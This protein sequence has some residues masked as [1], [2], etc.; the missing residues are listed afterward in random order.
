VF[1][2]HSSSTVAVTFSGVLIDH[3]AATGTD[4][5]SGSG[6]VGGQVQ[7]GGIAANGGALT[8][9]KTT[10][11]DNTAA[12]GTGAANTGGDGISGGQAYGGGVEA[13]G[14]SLTVTNSTIT[15]NTLSG[16]VGGTGGSSHE[17][18][19]GGSANGAGIY[20]E[21][22]GA[23]GISSS[24]L[25]GNRGTG[26]A[27]GPAGSGGHGGEGGCA[28]GGG[29]YLEAGGGSRTIA[30]DTISDN[31]VTGGAAGASATTGEPTYGSG[32][33]VYFDTAGVIE[34]TT[35]SGNHA[36]GGAPTAA[37]AGGAISPNGSIPGLVAVVNS[38]VFG[39]TASGPGSA[40]GGQGG[41]LETGSPL[42]LASDTFDANGF[43]GSHGG[44]I[45]S[46][47]A[48]LV[49][50]EDTIIAGGVGSS[51]A[52]NCSA[53]T[54]TD[55]PP[56]HNLEDD[57]GAQCGFSAGGDKV[58]VDPLLPAALASN[59][60][61]TQ[62]LALAPNS[63]ARG[64][65]GACLNPITAGPLLLDQ[66]GDA[67]GASPA[68]VLS[69]VRESH[70]RWRESGR[71]AHESRART[72]TGTKFSFRLSEAASVTF[73]FSHK[74]RK[75][76]VLT[77]HARAGRDALAFYGLLR[78]HH[79]LKPGKYKVVIVATSAGKRSRRSSLTFTIVG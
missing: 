36:I 28:C 79:E 1:I 57:A 49:H 42:T 38:T 56:G 74:G 77:V 62:T 50:A 76:G 11:A 32:G 52:Q 19:P 58:G 7:G 8:L 25:T 3:N 47:A 12:A 30:G 59:G 33:G 72:P 48:G 17:G 31:T 27:G 68:P 18:G 71:A 66:R 51:T 46:F 6:D 63:P 20:V 16:G 78:R 35:L 40:S 41:G 9:D 10:I 22:S 15:G 64:A 73:T 43:S 5:T 23:G 70:K 26:G 29:V 24:T 2:D 13:S 34:D 44:N 39:N 14:R 75:R 37:G 55:L 69:R 67:R 65:G 45:F 53:G 60:G 4:A 54:V 21:S 61:S